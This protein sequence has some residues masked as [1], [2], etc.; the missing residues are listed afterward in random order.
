MCGAG[1]DISSFLSGAG[2]QGKSVNIEPERRDRAW[3]VHCGRDA[4]AIPARHR[5][6][7]PPE[8]AYSPDLAFHVDSGSRARRQ[9]LTARTNTTAGSEV[10]V[11]QTRCRGSASGVGGTKRSDGPVGSFRYRIGSRHCRIDARATVAKHTRQEW[12][13]ARA[14]AR[15][16]D[17][18][19]VLDEVEQRSPSEHHRRNDVRRRTAPPPTAGR[20]IS[21][22]RDRR[23]G[24]A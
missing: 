10:Y 11:Q 5:P 3:L 4:T 19:T 23:P 17:G 16:M 8:H 2:R 22:S 14:Q 6:P 1:D 21:L 7:P 9:A 18:S 15:R 13:A 20:G 12:P 24:S